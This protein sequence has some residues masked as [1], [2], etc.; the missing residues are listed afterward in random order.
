[1]F[2]NT[3]LFFLEADIL[4]EFGEENG[5]KLLI[6]KVGADNETYVVPRSIFV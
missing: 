3:K 2:K 6:R 4:Q 1:M 5:Q